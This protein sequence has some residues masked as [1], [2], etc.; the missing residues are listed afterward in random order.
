MNDKLFIIARRIIATLWLYGI[1]GEWAEDFLFATFERAQSIG[2]RKRILTS[3]VS[4][5]TF[6]N[7]QTIIK[8]LAGNEQCRLIPEP[9]NPYDKSAIGVHVSF[10]GI[11]AH[12][13]YIPRDLAAVIV[14]FVET[15][16]ATCE[17]IEVTGRREEDATRGLLLRIE[18]PDTAETK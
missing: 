7:R 14:S 4:G 3:K 18:L 6:D 10:N 1:L 11:W 8:Q 16:T 12:V 15:D 17:L 9:H 5:V 13:G 2:P